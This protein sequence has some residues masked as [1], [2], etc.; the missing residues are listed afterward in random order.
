MAI[1]ISD[2]AD[3]ADDLTK[4]I[5]DAK[6][7]AF[8]KEGNYSKAAQGFARG[9]GMTTDIALKSSRVMSISL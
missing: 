8:D 7:A 4:E 2:V 1:L 3:Q 6:K 5:K 9:Q